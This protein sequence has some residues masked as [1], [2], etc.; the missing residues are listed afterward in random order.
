MGRERESFVCQTEILSTM[1][2]AI[3]SMPQTNYRR[4]HRRPPICKWMDFR[5][6]HNFYCSFELRFFVFHCWTRTTQRTGEK[7]VFFGNKIVAEHCERIHWLRCTQRELRTHE[8]AHYIEPTVDVAGLVFQQG[9]T[10]KWKR[11]MC[12]SS[13]I[14]W[15]LPQRRLRHNMHTFCSHSSPSRWRGQI[16]AEKWP[17]KIYVFCI[18]KWMLETNLFWFER[19]AANATKERHPHA[20]TDSMNHFDATT[21]C[22]HRLAERNFQ[23]KNCI[24]FGPYRSRTRQQLFN[25]QSFPKNWWVTA[26]EK[27]SVALAADIWFRACWCFVLENLQNFWWLLLSLSKAVIQLWVLFS[28]GSTGNV[29]QFLDPLQKSPTQI[30]LNIFMS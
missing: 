29:R 12:L 14:T 26:A 9:R 20:H 11:R 22:D 24:L 28:V 15:H 23:R 27:K 4:S 6:E 5:F 18:A 7:W 17:Q 30:K 25:A 13:V 16:A 21:V 1:H 19:R 2:N 3:C 10:Q 8:I